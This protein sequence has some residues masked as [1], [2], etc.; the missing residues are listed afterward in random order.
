MNT[1]K[2]NT[3]SQQREAVVQGRSLSPHRLR[4]NHHS[5][6]PTTKFFSCHY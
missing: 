1:L 3:Q 6:K 2:L 5:T 4:C